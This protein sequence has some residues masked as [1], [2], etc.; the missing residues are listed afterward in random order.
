MSLFA[1]GEERI[2]A[3]EEQTVIRRRALTERQDLDIALFQ[4]LEPTGMPSRSDTKDGDE[5]KTRHV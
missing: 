1:L 2:G 3:S 4:S 5:D